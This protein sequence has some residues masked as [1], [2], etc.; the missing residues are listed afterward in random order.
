MSPP[1]QAQRTH[2]VN[3]DV[4]IF[5]EEELS[6]MHQTRRREGAVWMHLPFWMDFGVDVYSTAGVI[7]GINSCSRKSIKTGHQQVK[8]DKGTAQRNL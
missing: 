7:T 8:H 2:L 6:C 1:T 4:H 5:V 3:L